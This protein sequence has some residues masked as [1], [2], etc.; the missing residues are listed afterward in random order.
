MS[1][2]EVS[3]AEEAD[4][5]PGLCRVAVGIP[6]ALAAA[7]EIDGGAPGP[8]EGEGHEGHQQVEL[9]RVGEAGVLEVEAAGLGVA[10]HAL[11]GPAL[12]V[13]G[14]RGAGRQV[15]DDD[16]PLGREA[17][18]GEVEL[19]GG[20]GVLAAVGPEPGAE[21]PGLPG[22]A[23]AGEQRELAAVRG[24]DAQVLAQPDG[25]GDI[26]LVEEFQPVGADELPVGQ[27]L[28]DGRGREMGEI[29]LDQ[30]DADLGRAV[31]AARQ[32]GPDQ[33]HPE[34]ARDEGE[35][36][37]VHLPRPDRPL[38][39]VEHQRPVAA[40]PMSCATSGSVQS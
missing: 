27:Q 21:R 1:G 15:G 33:R 18:D 24:D 32:Q 10:E 17:L 25:E 28:A 16:Q 2:E 5:E 14:E 13:G 39:P 30:R 12:A 40:G 34:V 37:I 29:A 3:D 22:A 26:V 23:Q 7:V 8:D 4:A 19:R 11:D 20:L 35:H 36:Q 6:L 31:A 38:R 9:A